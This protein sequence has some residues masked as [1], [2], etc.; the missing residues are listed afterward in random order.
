MHFF[1]IRHQVARGVHGPINRGE[2]TKKPYHCKTPDFFYDIHAGFINALAL[3][4]DGNYLASA[5]EAAVFL[6]QIE[7]IRNLSIMHL[8]LD[9]INVNQDLACLTRLKLSETTS[10]NHIKFS[11]DNKLLAGAASNGKVY[12]WN[13]A[14]Y[15]DS[16]E[17]LDDLT[18]A[19]TYVAFSSDSKSI[20]AG[21]KN[22]QICVWD[23]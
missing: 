23:I 22:G 12:V 16:P 19:A 17:I 7:T 18:S 11:P 8:E 15:Y 4:P 20:V 2:N 13:M 3:S 21:S 14:N 10:I 9:A 6:W 1:N 5:S